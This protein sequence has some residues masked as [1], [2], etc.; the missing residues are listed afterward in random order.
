MKINFLN[1]YFQ[2]IK[3]EKK[4][5]MYFANFSFSFLFFQQKSNIK[6]NIIMIHTNTDT[7]TISKWNLLTFVVTTMII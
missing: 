7:H 4:D 6:Q 5:E 3:K 2:I 1:F